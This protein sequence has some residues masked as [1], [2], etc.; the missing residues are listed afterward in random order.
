MGA[1][2]QRNQ[3]GH[4][5][6]GGSVIPFDLSAGTPLTPASFSLHAV[7]VVLS[8]T[9]S[10]TSF[11]LSIYSSFSNWPPPWLHFLVAPPPAPKSQTCYGRAGMLHTKWA[12][13][14]DPGG[15]TLWSCRNT[16][17]AAVCGLTLLS[18]FRRLGSCG[19]FGRLPCHPLAL[20]GPTAPHSCGCH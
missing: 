4:G 17:H 18:T 2:P 14:K 8:Y 10:L 12:D 1:S 11:H 9:S 15:T 13:W 6:K 3:T 19:A 7:P 16:Q 5:R 20:P